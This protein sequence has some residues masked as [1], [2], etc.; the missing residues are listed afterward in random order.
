M[1]LGQREKAKPVGPTVPLQPTAESVQHQSSGHTEELMY[2]HPPLLA[3]H[4]GFGS[5]EE[6]HQLHAK[7]FASKKWSSPSHSCLP[8]LLS[9]QMQGHNPEPCNNTELPMY[10]TCILRKRLQNT[11]RKMQEQTNL[12]KQFH[13]VP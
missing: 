12:P 3:P 10:W 7:P 6:F 9:S 8:G 13:S 11:L 1:S 2:H 5:S 4:A